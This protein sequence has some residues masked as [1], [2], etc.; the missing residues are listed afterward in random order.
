[1]WNFITHTG[2]AA[3]AMD[4]TN[5]FSV[6]G[7]GLIG[8]TALSAAMITFAAIQE[9]RSRETEAMTEAAHTPGDYQ[10]AA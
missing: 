3:V 8:L 9:H 5:D 6:L 10:E 2:I 4:F 7:I 1:M